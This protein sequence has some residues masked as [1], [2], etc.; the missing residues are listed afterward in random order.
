MRSEQQ[1][2][3][4]TASLLNELV[5]SNFDQGTLLHHEIILAAPNERIKAYQVQAPEGNL[6][7]K[8]YTNFP[9]EGQAEFANYQH[10]SSLSF[11]PS[12]RYYDLTSSTDRQ[13]FAY[14][15]VDGVD[16][17]TDLSN[18]RD[19]GLY[20]STDPILQTIDQTSK[21]ALLL[22]G[23][24]SEFQNDPWALRSPVRGGF[25]SHED[26]SAFLNAY[27][28]TLRMNGEAITA[29]PGYYFDR[30]PRNILLTQENTYQIDFGV[31]EYASP[32]FDLAKLLRNGVDVSKVVTADDFLELGAVTT[33]QEEDI[34]D[35]FY[36]TKVD[37][38]ALSR[39][40]F[41]LFFDH[42]ALH[43]HIFYLTKYLKMLSDGKGE[44]KVLTARSL[45]HLGMSHRT[46]HSLV[47][48]GEQ[49]ENMHT[50]VE[51][52]VQLTKN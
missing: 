36:T 42:V 21:M 25:L 20:C 10:F 9:K 22:T 13:V 47:N 46:I 7:V 30:N 40:Q 2:Q 4:I 3:G 45:Y 26:H 52:F 39:D 35:Y 34:K 31:I 48:R 29:I 5:R 27:S 23:K 18:T 8:V 43:T 51:H 11:V 44:E 15:Y 17:H 6:F 28:L 38:T 50:W 49:V 1:G 16:L 12:L 14:D 24:E 41:D 37:A 32:I 33:V 19:Q